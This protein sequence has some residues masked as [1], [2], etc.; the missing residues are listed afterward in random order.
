MKPAP[1][2]QPGQPLSRYY[3]GLAAFLRTAYFGRIQVVAR[4]P[5]A[6]EKTGP[7]LIVSSHRNGAL[8][9]YVVLT[10]FPLAQFLVSI[11]LLRKWVLRLL[12]TGIPVVREKDRQ[13]YGLDRTTVANPVD[14]GV[15][16][17]KA[18]GDLI[19]FPEGSSE[20]RPNP[21]PYQRGAAKMA[22]AL[23]TAGVPVQVIPMGLHYPQPDRFRSPVDLVTG[24]PIVLPIRAPE[25]ADK[26]WEDRLHTAISDALRAVSVNCPDEATFQAA[27]AQAREA[28]LDGQPSYGEAF[29]E[30]QRGVRGLRDGPH[31]AH[32]V[33]AWEKGL[34]TCSALVFA[35]IVLG[36]WLAGRKADARNTVSFF[37]VLGGLAG[38]VLWLPMIGAAGVLWPWPTVV[39]LAVGVLGW[40]R[41]PVAVSH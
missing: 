6:L 29:L 16:H 34:L 5:K 15:A 30:A 10:A 8:D 2:A 33:R 13:R 41:Y 12:F 9:G 31:Q 19:V 14:A 11:Q 28:V 21:L 17:L 18:G 32:R 38:A 36:A 3:R 4:N 25:E 22:A 26:V 40:W 35:P 20:W 1:G 24:D 39:A 27:E 37:R 7:R 23:L